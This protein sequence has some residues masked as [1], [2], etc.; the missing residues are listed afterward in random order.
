MTHTKWDA[1]AL[2]FGGLGVEIK[3]H[4]EKRCFETSSYSSDNKEGTSPDDGYGKDTWT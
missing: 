2:Q 4:P 1:L 3:P